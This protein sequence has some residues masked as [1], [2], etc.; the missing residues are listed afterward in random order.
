MEKKRKPWLKESK[1]RARQAA[2][3]RDKN[4][5][6]RGEAHPNYKS[7]KNRFCIDCGKK[8]QHRNDRLRCWNC[9][10]KQQRGK[11]HSCWKGGGGIVCNCNYCNK[12]IRKPP[13]DY[14]RA[15]KHFCNKECE[16]SY[17]REFGSKGKEH[18]NYKNGLSP[19]YQALRTSVEY[20]E[21]RNAVFERD[22]FRCKLCEKGGMLNA[23]HVIKVKT[24]LL[25]NN[26]HNLSEARKCK[27]L[28]DINNGITLC[29]DCHDILHSSRKYMK[30]DFKRYEK[31]LELKEAV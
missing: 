5:Y 15:K 8:F 18:H 3:K 13:R 19:L 25:E 12:E 9:Y 29:E 1:E 22:G 14:K 21:W 7:E 31:Y 10:V 2:L 16:M 27:A 6:L 23:H 17:R 30:K 4:T 26:I 11:T 28:W 24:I 20:K